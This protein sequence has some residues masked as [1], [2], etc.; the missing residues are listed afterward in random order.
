MQSKV[1]FTNICIGVYAVAVL[2]IT[3]YHG[4]QGRV[5]LSE[6]VTQ[7]VGLCPIRSAKVSMASKETTDV[8][9]AMG[10]R[11]LK[12]YGQ[13]ELITPPS[14]GLF[15]PVTVLRA[16]CYFRKHFCNQ[17]IQQQRDIFSALCPLPTYPFFCM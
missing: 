9:I 2:G 4:R 17:K 15:V 11:E 13:N 8:S 12:G 16:F 1:K 6:A 10:G 14:D 7:S 3:I 5:M